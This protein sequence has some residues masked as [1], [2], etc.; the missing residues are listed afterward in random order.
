MPSE[1]S[2]NIFSKFIALPEDDGRNTH[3]LPDQQQGE[4]VNYLE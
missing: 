1:R 3:A 2:L 4:F